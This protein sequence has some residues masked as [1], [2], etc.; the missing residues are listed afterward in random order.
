MNAAFDVLII[1][2]GPIGLA[3]ALEAKRA[4]LNYII[5]EKG[6]VTNSLY[7]YPLYMTFFFFRKTGNRECT[8]CIHQPQAY[9]AGSIGI[10]P[11]SYYLSSAEYQAV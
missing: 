3:C 5:I 10:L 2:G 9:P 11:E 6:C 4:G 1:G 8:F 7:N